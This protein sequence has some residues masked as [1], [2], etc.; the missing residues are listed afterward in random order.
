MCEYCDTSFYEVD[1][2]EDFGIT[3]INHKPINIRKRGSRV[4][5]VKG[6]DRMYLRETKGAAL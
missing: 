1:N 6:N 4:K 3:F 5:A 2:R